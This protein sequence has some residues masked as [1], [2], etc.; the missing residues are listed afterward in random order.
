MQDAEEPIVEDCSKG[1]RKG[2]DYVK[3]SF[4]PDFERFSMHGLD[5]DAAALISKRAYDVS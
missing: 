1:E 2:G 4:K 3:I 5:E